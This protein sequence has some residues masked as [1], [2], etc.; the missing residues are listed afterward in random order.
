MVSGAA[1]GSCPN[2]AETQQKSDV[3][4]DASRRSIVQRRIDGWP[5]MS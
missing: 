1:G 2:K 5:I 3:P 4:T